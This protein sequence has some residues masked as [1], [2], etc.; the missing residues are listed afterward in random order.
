MGKYLRYLFVD[1]V[2]Y[3]RQKITAIYSLLV[4]YNLFVWL[5]AFY[6]FHHNPLLFGTAVLAYT[7]GLR[8]ALDAD[9]LAAIDNVTRKLIQ[10]GKQPVSAG[11]CFSLG[12][13]AVVFM[14]TL[15]VALATAK[16]VPHHLARW[17]EIGN[18]VC[19]FLSS[20][21]LILISFINLFIFISL[22]KVFQQARRGNK[23][24][25]EDIDQ[26][27]SS[28]GFLAK[29]FR[30]FFQIITHSW[31]MFP[32]GFLFGLSLDTAT[33]IILMGI[34]AAETVHGLSFWSLLIFPALFTAG[35]TLL[36]TT[37][38]ILMLG[39]YGWALLKPVRKLYY[40]LS[41]T[42]ISIT[43]AFSLGIIEILGLIGNQIKANGYMWNLIK[44]L[45]SHFEILGYI[46]ISLFIASWLI[47]II[48]Y[49]LMQFGKNMS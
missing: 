43:L 12:H 26:L 23:S 11:L 5:G 33:E 39:A 42:F 22:F 28:Q 40:N 24:T 18:I 14:A 37:D 15:G 19:T 7:F 34:S 8:H 1:Q 47:S 3:L 45:N 35:M 48:V 36:D 49:K 44:A 21:F 46:I 2:G 16:L 38:S 25:E 6:F 32:L 20:L 10:E 9:H 41:I 31:Q 17:H 30:H 4:L 13:S 27:I 29:Y